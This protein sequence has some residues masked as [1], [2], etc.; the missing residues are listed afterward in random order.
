MPRQEQTLR[1]WPNSCISQ[2]SWGNTKLMQLSPRR[3]S[4]TALVVPTAPSS[5]G[6]QYSQEVTAD[7][8][9]Y[10]HGDDHPVTAEWERQPWYTGLEKELPGAEIRSE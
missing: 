4:Q 7:S 8:S 6:R 5:L 3:R 2:L 9:G 1:S 10:Q